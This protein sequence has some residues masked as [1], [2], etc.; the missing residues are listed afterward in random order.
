[1]RSGR[2]DDAIMQL[3]PLLKDNPNFVQARYLSGL[4]LLGKNDLAGANTQFETVNKLNPQLAE[5]HYSL[6]RT[7]LARGD[8]EGAK[9][10]YQRAAELAPD[11]KQ[12]KMELAAAMGGK[13]DPAMVSAWIEELKTA[14]AKDPTN[15][16]RR[17]DLGRAYL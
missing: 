4:A 2:F 11:N 10:E 13:P 14:L 15:V 17:E 9:K 5:S 7:L 16:A 8:V 3:S 6:A 1:I 12:V